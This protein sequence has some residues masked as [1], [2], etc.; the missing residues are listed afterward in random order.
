MN[1]K[2][3]E[4]ILFIKERTTSWS[5][6]KA[7]IVENCSKRD[8]IPCICFLTLF[9]FFN[10]NVYN[11][12]FQNILVMTSLDS[13]FWINSNHASCDDFFHCTCQIT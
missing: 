3:F 9:S 1:G 8:L 11:L 13:Y 2:K 10:F 6:T 4:G 5:W 12:F 7:P